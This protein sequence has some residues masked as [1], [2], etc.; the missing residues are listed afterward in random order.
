MFCNFREFTH[1]GGV[2]VKDVDWPGRGHGLFDHLFNASIGGQLAGGNVGLDA[3]GFQFGEGCFKVFR[4]PPVDDDVAAAFG[5]S[6]GNL[7]THAPA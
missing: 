1:D 7:L 5:Q 6:P 3:K 2:V 4:I